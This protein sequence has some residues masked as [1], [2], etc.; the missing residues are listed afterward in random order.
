MPAA[1]TSAFE[2][3]QTLTPELLAHIEH[4]VW[5]FETG[6]RYR[7]LD[8]RAEFVGVFPHGRLLTLCQD[9]Q[10]L[11]T[12]LSLQKPVAT[13]RGTTIDAHYL[14]TLSVWPAAHGRGL[15]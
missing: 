8:R 11:A 10:L 2:R 14:T 13:G 5:G 7:I 4:V 15:A 1:E 9:K 12:L 6:V 3:T